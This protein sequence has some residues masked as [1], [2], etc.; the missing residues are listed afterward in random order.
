[1][2]LSVPSSS[3]KTLLN[4]SFDC[5]TKD[6]HAAVRKCIASSFHEVSHLIVYDIC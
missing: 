3:F 5:L 6:S 2:L 1:M 4:S